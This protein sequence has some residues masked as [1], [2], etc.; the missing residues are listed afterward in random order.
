MNT[1]DDKP[2]GQEEQIEVMPGVFIP[3]RLY[4]LEQQIMGEHKRRM[5]EYAERIAENLRRR[6][7]GKE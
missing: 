3:Y 1:S 4:V 7:G 5:A 2:Q 6:R